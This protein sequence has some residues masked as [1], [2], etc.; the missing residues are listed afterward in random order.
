M[1]C[2]LSHIVRRFGNCLQRTTLA[3]YSGQPLGSTPVQNLAL[4]ACL[5]AALDREFQLR[6][7]EPWLAVALDSVALCLISA[8]AAPNQ[9][10]RTA[11]SSYSLRPTPCNC[12]WERSYNSIQ[13][14]KVLALGVPIPVCM[15]AWLQIERRSEIQGPK[16]IVTVITTARDL[17]HRSRRQG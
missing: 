2:Q 16:G 13:S 11:R 9:A 5:A 7:P 15:L 10:G 1:T 3:P 4:E 12:W 8:H 6:L 14:V 17:C